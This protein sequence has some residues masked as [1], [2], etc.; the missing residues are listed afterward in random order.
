VLQVRR[1]PEHRE[2]TRHE[3]K[4]DPFE[5][6]DPRAPRLLVCRCGGAYTEP[7]NKALPRFRGRARRVRRQVNSDRSLALL[8]V[9]ALI[10]GVLVYCMLSV[11][12]SIWLPDVNLFPDVPWRPLD[13]ALG[14]PRWS[15]PS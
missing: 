3:H 9:L 4:F 15:W 14:P 6:P 2:Y 11:L 12:L 5:Q 1:S 8:I 10:M 7:P 13:G